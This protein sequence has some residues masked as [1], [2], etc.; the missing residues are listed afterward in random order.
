MFDNAP[1]HQK[2]ASDA[3][4]ACKMVKNPKLGWSHCP[5]GPCMCPAILPE[6]LLSVVYG[7]RTKSYWHSAL[8]SSV[9]RAKLIAAV[10]DCCSTSQTLLLRSPSSRRPLSDVDISV[11]STQ[12]I[13]V[14][15]ILLSSTGVQQSSLI[16][17]DQRLQL[18]LKWSRK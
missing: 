12:S 16:E 3:L 2:C 6:S 9:R 10:A 17:V 13:T 11:T 5:D 14:S 1:S 8:V 4:S 7:Q 18:W 15:S